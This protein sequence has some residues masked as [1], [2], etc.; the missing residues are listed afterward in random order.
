[1]SVMYLVIKFYWAVFVISLEPRLLWMFDYEMFDDTL[2]SD[3]LLHSVTHSV[4]IVCTLSVLN[5]FPYKS[6][7]M[8]NGFPYRSVMTCLWS[9]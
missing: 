2:T 6:L 8:L 1:M 5:G 3:S 7:S 9:G 4:V